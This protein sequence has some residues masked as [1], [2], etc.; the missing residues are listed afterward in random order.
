MAVK[1]AHQYPADTRVRTVHQQGGVGHGQGSRQEGAGQESGRRERH[2]DE[3]GRTT[4]GSG[5]RQRDHLRRGQIN[6]DESGSTQ[7]KAGSA[8]IETEVV[9]LGIER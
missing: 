4:G 7:E 6:G 3:E 9:G 8:A 5:D 2:R 1:F